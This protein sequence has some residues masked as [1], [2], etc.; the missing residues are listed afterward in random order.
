MFL[1][2]SREAAMVVVE[3]AVFLRRLAEAARARAEILAIR[4]E[5][6][7]AAAAE[8]LQKAAALRLARA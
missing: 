4:M 3:R 8:K 1:P 5:L 7:L 2:L 6:L